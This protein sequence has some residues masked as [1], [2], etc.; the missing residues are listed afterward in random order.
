MEIQ[1]VPEQAL[2]KALEAVKAQDMAM[3]TRAIMVKEVM[4]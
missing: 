2:N 4:I 1:V 3:A